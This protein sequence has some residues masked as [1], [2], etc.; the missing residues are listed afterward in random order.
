L[1]SAVLEDEVTVLA[2]SFFCFFFISFSIQASVAERPTHRR[3]KSVLLNKYY[4]LT[5]LRLQLVIMHEHCIFLQIFISS[6]VDK[7]LKETNKYKELY[8]TYKL[9]WSFKRFFPVSMYFFSQAASRYL[10][11]V[12]GSKTMYSLIL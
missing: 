1:M 2:P 6:L 4:Q 3:I 7:K 5:H 10:S 9:T 11:F 8:V 12:T